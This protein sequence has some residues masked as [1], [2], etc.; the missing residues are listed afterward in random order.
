MYMYA[1][2]QP[3]LS[4]GLCSGYLGFTREPIQLKTPV[5]F[6]SLHT[7]AKPITLNA[8]TCR[9]MHVMYIVVLQV[10]PIYCG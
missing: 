6:T 2:G 5:K 4:G 3:E 9:Y 10:R 1:S 7:H 8:C